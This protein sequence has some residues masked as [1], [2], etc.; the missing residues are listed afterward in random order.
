MPDG[1]SDDGRGPAFESG[2]PSGPFDTPLAAEAAFYDAIERADLAAL[3]AVWATN[4]EIV[5]V[6]PGID[7]VEG[8][9]AVLAS[10]ARMFAGEARLGFEIVDV[11]FADA[12]GLAVHHARE[13][14]RVQGRVV[15][16]L[17]ATNVYVYQHDGWRML[18]HHA[19]HESGSPLEQ[20]AT[21]EQRRAVRVPRKRTLH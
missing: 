11:V 3:A 10:F 15:G 5:C 8:R 20:P 17:A 4:D 13:R 12:D 7:R 18:M 6:H 21:E 1:D 2:G 16:I 9:E 19:S 14:V